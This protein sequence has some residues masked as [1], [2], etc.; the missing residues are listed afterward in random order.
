MLF[1]IWDCVFSKDQ[2]ES[3]LASVI[4]IQTCVSCCVT[5]HTKKPNQF[6]KAWEIGNLLKD[7][8]M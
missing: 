2:V 5:E 4:V 8:S 1:L 3:E 6:L 7:L